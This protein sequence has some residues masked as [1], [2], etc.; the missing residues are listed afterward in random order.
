MH[1]ADRGRGPPFSKAVAP[2][3]LILFLESFYAKGRRFFVYR[4]VFYGKV[5][6]GGRLTEQRSQVYCR[7]PGTPFSIHHPGFG[8]HHEESRSRHPHRHS[9]QPHPDPGGSARQRAATGLDPGAGRRGDPAR[10]VVGATTRARHDRLPVHRDGGQPGL[11]HRRAVHARPGTC[12]ELRPDHAPLDERR[13]QAPPQ[14]RTPLRPRNPHGV[15]DLRTAEPQV[16]VGQRDLQ[17]RRNRLPRGS[18]HPD[19]L[20]H[21]LILSA[22]RPLAPTSRTRASGLASSGR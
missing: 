10:A 6:L 14:Q 17:L 3:P 1:P 13:V 4:Q 5:S 22:A 21:A 18:T 12:R 15:A 11:R 2:R 9:V 20:P 7:I 8:E 19:R 16:L